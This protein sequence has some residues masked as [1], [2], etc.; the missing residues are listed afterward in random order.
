[1]SSYYTPDGRNSYMSFDAY[2]SHLDQQ[3]PGWAQRNNQ[4]QQQESYNQYVYNQT[5]GQ[6]G[7]AAPAGSTASI[8]AGNTRIANSAANAHRNAIM[9]YNNSMPTTDDILEPYTSNIQNVGQ[10]SIQNSLSELMSAQAKSNMNLAG[11]QGL[12]GMSFAPPPPNVS[13]TVTIYNADG[14]PMQTNIWDFT[15]QTKPYAM[16]A[17]D[18]YSS[19][20][21]H[22]N[23]VQ[24]N[25]ASLDK[26]IRDR[27]EAEDD[28]YNFQTDIRTQVGSLAGNAY[29][30]SIAD[31][32]LVDL[33]QV[34]ANELRGQIG[35]F[36][37]PLQDPDFSDFSYSLNGLNQVDSRLAKVLSD[38]QSELDRV[39]SF[40]AN[41]GSNLSGAENTL[42]GLGIADIDQIRGLQSD[43]RNY[44]RSLNSFN[45]LLSDEFDF[46]PFHGQTEDINNALYELIQNRSTEESRLNTEQQRLSNLDNQV[47]T[48]LQRLDTRNLANIEENR[49]QVD[50]AMAAISG[51]TSDLPYDFSSI[52][53][54]LSSHSNS[55]DGLLAQRGIELDQYGSTLTGLQDRF[56]ALNLWDED[57]FQKLSRE[58]QREFADL[59]FYQGGRAPGLQEQY[60]DFGLSIDDKLQ[61]L[62]GHRDDLEQEAVGYLDEVGRGF[63][64]LDSL[65]AFR[66]ALS[67]F[68]GTVDQ[69]DARQVDDELRALDISMKEEEARLSAELAAVRKREQ[70]EAMRA[71]QL[72]VFYNNPRA[73]TPT[74]YS[75]LLAQNSQGTDENAYISPTV[76]S[77]LFMNGAV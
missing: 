8:G 60:E 56:D 12:A 68:R 37:T 21:P 55:L 27:G 31:P 20:R 17:P 41:M 34:G 4:I 11:L 70:E 69:Y 59:A 22:I 33:Y 76:F 75:A 25:L 49:Y 43:V 65:E 61:E 35:A 30:V 40:Q 16:E 57:D 19:A 66:E 26:L 39:S 45:S 7:A 36:N 51:F 62:Y 28:F 48:S 67:S 54:N 14:K 2:V 72:S 5:G 52:A 47:R 13:D 74:E 23:T 77:S 58:G 46:N 71:R 6:Y 32:D 18:V 3:K 9:S 50:D 44:Q 53:S 63:T 73:L 29:G 15:G 24:N 38:R 64:D 42:S 10:Y 1:M